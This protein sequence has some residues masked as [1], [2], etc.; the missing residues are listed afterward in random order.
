M[1]RKR[2]INFALFTVISSMLLIAG[3]TTLAQQPDFTQPGSY[4]VKTANGYIF[5]RNG[6]EKSLRFEVVGKTVEPKEVAQNHGFIVDGRV[7]QVLI[8]DHDEYE[9]SGKV[10]SSD[11][12]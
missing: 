7:V 5:I 3:S 12:L 11:L 8:V 4:S 10:A 1:K 2:V 6:K 9:P